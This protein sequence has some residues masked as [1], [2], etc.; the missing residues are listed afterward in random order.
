MEKG[1]YWVIYDPS[2]D[3]WEV[4]EY[5]G[6]NRD[7]FRT[8]DETFYG[9]SDFSG[10]HSISPWILFS[11]QKPTE[12]GAY[13]YFDGDTVE[14]HWY[15]PNDE[16]WYEGIHG[17]E[18]CPQPSNPKWWMPLPSPPNKQNAVDA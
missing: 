15:S 11:E 16:C 8:G 1:F 10:W 13:L 12:S 5:C 4:V 14:I 9:T 3:G 7:T 2:P 18:S 17:D 6:P